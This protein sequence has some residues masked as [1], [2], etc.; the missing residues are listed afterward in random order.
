MTEKEKMINSMLYNPMD[1]ELVRDRQHARSCV[2][3]S[4][5]L[6]LRRKKKKPPF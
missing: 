3:S 5:G 6:N 1:E 4:M 2:I